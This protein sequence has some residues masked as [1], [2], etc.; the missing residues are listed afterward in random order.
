LTATQRAK[1]KNIAPPRGS[2]MLE[3]NQR[4]LIQI[5][6]KNRQGY[7]EWRA[8]QKF[9]TP[10]AVSYLAEKFWRDHREKFPI[11]SNIAQKVF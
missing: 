5:S 7:Q 11:L 1:K 8:A 4:S 2:A 6:Y 10:N 9:D 3:T